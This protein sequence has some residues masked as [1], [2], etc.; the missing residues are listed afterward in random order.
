M[1][2]Y[3]MCVRGTVPHRRETVDMATVLDSRTDEAVQDHKLSGT[4][5]QEQVDAILA[6]MRA[7]GYAP[8]G[9]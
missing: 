9:A 7:T 6:S 5:S 2:G 4:A 1:Y 3:I 8:A